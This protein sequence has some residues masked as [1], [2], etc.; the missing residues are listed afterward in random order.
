[1]D[2]ELLKALANMTPEQ[3]LEA[4]Q[5]GQLVGTSGAQAVP[6][7]LPAT[8]ASPWQPGVGLKVTEGQPI[9]M[10]AL[11][12]GAQFG[13]AKTAIRPSVSGAGAP[14]PVRMQLPES[15][16]SLSA[17][18]PKPFGLEDLLS[19]DRPVP[20]AG[21]PAPAAPLRSLPIPELPG[22]PLPT[23]RGSPVAAAGAPVR[24]TS[25]PQLPGMSGISQ[26]E[27]AFGAGQS[28]Q[29]DALRQYLNMRGGQPGLAGAVGGGMGSPIP[30]PGS[31][32][33][34]PG[35]APGVP[36]PAT[37]AMPTPAA[38]APTPGAAGGAAPAA[39]RF[40]KVLG[41][42]RPAVRGVLGTAGTAATVYGLA[43]DAG[44]LAGKALDARDQSLSPIENFGRG[45]AAVG[46]EF[47]P[48]V[49]PQA[50]PTRE[51]MLT[52]PAGTLQR[53]QLANAGGN[54]PLFR[55]MNPAAVAT[56][57]AQALG[58]L[59][60]QAINWAITRP[61]AERFQDAQ[62]GTAATIRAAMD[63]GQSRGASAFDLGN[64]K[65]ADPGA[66]PPA[67][68]VRPATPGS[69]PRK[70]PAAPAIPPSP[71]TGVSGGS[72]G[73]GPGPYKL[74]DKKLS[75]PMVENMQASPSPT[76]VRPGGPSPAWSSSAP[77]G[78]WAGR[79][80]A[81]A[82]NDKRGVM[83]EGRRMPLGSGPGEG[84]RYGLDTEMKGNLAGSVRPSTGLN[85]RNAVPEY[86]EPGGEIPETEEDKQARLAA[87]K[88]KVSPIFAGLAAYSR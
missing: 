32:S 44:N 77:T 48:L 13:E 42:V 29:A 20:G 78:A 56:T 14:P 69:G 31:V 24:P 71:E 22:E 7:G 88:A 38:P 21:T 37:Q 30:T 75:V 51:E 64:P 35:T 79:G 12:E 4:L 70:R 72:P 9:P 86:L 53:A 73:A 5:S 8:P 81:S 39:S 43:K 57:S 60:E 18:R 83:G 46:S 85:L 61:G 65:P 6:P 55:Y 74:L 82:L 58:G 26:V 67:P 27:G 16:S 87:A 66:T 36:P 23:P 45:V 10:A 17:V 50:Q 68:A 3:L 41:A 80:M 52:D 59:A 19:S 76:A 34:V 2:P 47:A 54:V 33:G 11:R 25:M 15:S 84:A 40:S 63:S 28:A 1:M 49:M 62:P